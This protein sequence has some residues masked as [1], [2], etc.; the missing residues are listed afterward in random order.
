[1]TLL[2]NQNT[3]RRAVTSLKK[4]K[5]KKDPAE[6]TERSENCSR[7]IA[8]HS[9]QRGGTHKYTTWNNRG[10]RSPDAVQ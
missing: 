4:D 7:T 9:P 2:C 5:Y 1:M 3:V 8:L 10:F 6:L